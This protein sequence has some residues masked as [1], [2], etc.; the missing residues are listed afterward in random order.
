MRSP[1]SGRN[2]GS[3]SAQDLDHVVIHIDDWDA[4]HA[5][6]LGVLG[7]E[8]VVANPEA[9]GNPLDACAYRLGETQINVHGP[10]PGQHGDCCPAPYNEIGRADL[11]FRTSLT[12]EAV[13]ALLRTNDV[14]IVAGPVRRFGAMGWGSSVYCADPSGN[15]IELISYE[16]E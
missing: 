3:V 16:E 7:V 6:Y 11:A 1:R 9:S 12:P 8:R 14:E 13:V 2:A 10:W 4:A 15:G 5:F